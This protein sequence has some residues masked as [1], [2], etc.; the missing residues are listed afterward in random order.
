[1]IA[2]R[3]AHWVVVACCWLVLVAL[4]V[5]FAGDRRGT[6]LDY[7]A[8]GAVREVF[9]RP[10]G[11]LDVLLWI[12]E[13]P[14]LIAVV[15]LGAALLCWR[16]RRGFALLLLGAPVLTVLLVDVLLKPLI[17]RRF[18]GTYLCLP[19]GHTAGTVAVL[20][21]L[22]LAAWPTRWRLLGVLGWLAGTLAAG[23]SLIGFHFHYLTDVLGGLCVAVGTVLLVV[24]LLVTNR[25][26]GWITPK[27]RA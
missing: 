10:G 14:V 17:G 21:V 25:V 18:E 3:R 12:T 11:V 2:W 8:N 9:G 13:P 16:G 26:A 4:G 20:T 1:M 7:A 15:L 22:L 6:A 24:R 5:A 23:V 19:S 27:I